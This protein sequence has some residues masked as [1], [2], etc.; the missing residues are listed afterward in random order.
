MQIFSRISLLISTD[1]STIRLAI[2]LSDKGILA[3]FLTV[4]A[5][6]ISF[7]IILQAGSFNLSDTVCGCFDLATSSAARKLTLRAFSDTVVAYLIKS[8]SFLL[9][10][11]KASK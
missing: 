10:F 5:P 8:I 11:K 2:V 3:T 4:S 1:V 6:S 9:F 7:T